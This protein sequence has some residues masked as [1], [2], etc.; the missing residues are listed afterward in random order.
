MTDA[1]DSRLAD[2]ILLFCRTLR[3]AG[4]PVGP[5]QVV[6]AL[7]A[8]VSVGIERR[9]DFRSALRCVLLNDPAHFRIFDQTF[10]FYF[11]N[12]RL[13]ERVLALLLP[14]PAPTPGRGEKAMRRLAE[15]MSSPADRQAMDVAEV[16][17]DQAGS[18]SDRELL[19][20]KDFED[21]SL[22][23]QREA[24]LLMRARLGPLAELKSRRFRQHP[25]GSRPDLRRSMQLMMRRDGQLL[26][27]AR[28]QRRTRPPPLVLICDISGSMSHYSRMFLQ[29]AHAMT[30]R[31]L[32]VHSFVFGTRLTHVSRRLKIADPDQALAAVARDVK[33]F[34]GGTRI[35]AC[36][37]H[38]NVEWGR[39]VLAGN[40]VVVLL[41]DGLERDTESDL[42]FQV[43]RLHRSCRQLIWLNPMLRYTEFQPRAF[44]IRTMLPHVDRFLPAQR[45]P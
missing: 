19:G 12:P 32:T 44:G 30:A 3:S 17:V 6:D 11:R 45:A 10:H 34:D 31:A 41:S 28:K 39:R 23:E 29:F 4:I 18:C 38:F 13:L 37:R 33:D 43:S 14:S 15:A 36:L 2:N 1:D 20:D 21:M 5:A 35:A 26:T 7:R 42:E 22:A 8:V 24:A 9:D 16:D 25:L 27:L 40:A